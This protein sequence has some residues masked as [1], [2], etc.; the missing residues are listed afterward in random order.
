MPLFAVGSAEISD[1]ARPALLDVAARMKGDVRLSVL[2]RGHTDSAGEES[3]NDQLS[4]MR[5]RAAQEF[6]VAS[7]VSRDRIT[8]AGLGARELIDPADT[9]EARARNRRVEIVWKP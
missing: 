6:L 3:F 7:G 9:P 5:A 2:L 1:K 4:W 8:V